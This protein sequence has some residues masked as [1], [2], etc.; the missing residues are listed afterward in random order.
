MESKE[1]EA[2]ALLAR[3][4]SLADERIELD[5]DGAQQLAECSLDQLPRIMALADRVRRAHF[6]NRA[7]LCA[8]V[9]AKSGRC[10]EDCAFCAQSS[11]Y[12]CRIEEYDLLD[13]A[14]LLIAAE[15]AAAAGAYRF[16][17]VTSGKTPSAAEMDAL[18]ATVTEIRE[19]TGLRVCASLGVLDEEKLMRLKRAGVE[20]YHHNLETAQSFFG[21]ICTTHDYAEDV[22]TVRLARRVGLQVCV[23]GIFG[24]GETAAQRIELAALLNDLDVDA[25]PVNFLNPIPG[26]P[27]ENNGLLGPRE[28]L[29]ILALYRLMLP[30]REVIVCG[31]RGVNLGQFQSA[32]FFAGVSGMMIG[33]YLTTQGRA[34]EDDLQMVADLGLEAVKP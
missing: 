32:I 6:G 11:Y 33:N 29:R 22:A 20:R 2:V 10:S 27:L 31:G 25:V 1:K 7:G 5:A 8:I 17:L 26:T 9:N 14:K 21:E 34:T 3:L 18:C 16:S 28:C 13:A 12:D 24:L 19:R 30:R 15:A 23:G 4:E